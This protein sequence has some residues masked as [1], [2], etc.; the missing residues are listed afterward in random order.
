[1]VLHSPAFLF[2]RK[3]HIKPRHVSMKKGRPLS[4]AHAAQPLS[5][6]GIGAKSAN[7]NIV[8]PAPSKPPYPHELSEE[9]IACIPLQL[10]PMPLGVDERHLSPAL[11]SAA[12]SHRIKFANASSAA[13][14]AMRSM[15]QSWM[16]WLRLY[17]A[18]EGLCCMA[19]V[20][21]FAA[22][23]PL[24]TPFL[25]IQSQILSS[26]QT[27]ISNLWPMHLTSHRLGPQPRLMAACSCSQTRT[28]A[29][30]WTKASAP[31]VGETCDA[32][33]LIPPLTG[34]TSPPTCPTTLKCFSESTTSVYVQPP[35]ALDQLAFHAPCP[36]V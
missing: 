12:E 33:A 10:P 21:S 20:C 2:Y 8:H 25:T 35:H 18:S 26:L 9:A 5:G 6:M 30:A 15:R 11:I 36:A 29:V 4:R 7:L 19:F 27:P 22:A 3:L 34:S 28:P 32:F 13:R 24:P 31:A 14:S 16:T 17:D 23:A 1:M